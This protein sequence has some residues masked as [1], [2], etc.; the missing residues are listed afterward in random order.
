MSE[1]N[2]YD[3]YKL[4]HGYW[5][6]EI[7]NGIFHPCEGEYVH[8]VK[9]GY[10]IYYRS[11]KPFEKEGIYQEGTF[12]KGISNGFWKFYDILGNKFAEIIYIK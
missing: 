12:K 3:E 6:Q 10:W 9:E 11:N 1:I 7:A 5:K 4:R 8:G 2:Q